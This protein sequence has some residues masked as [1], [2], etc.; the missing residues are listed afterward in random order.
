V[1]YL[2][3]AAS[4]GNK[5]IIGLNSD[6]SVRKLKGSTRP[7]QN[8]TSRSHIL[9]SLGFVDAVVPFEED[10][11][12]LLIEM[13]RPDVLVKGGDWPTEKIAG[14]E[15]VQSYGGRVISIPL[16]EGH[17]TTNIEKRIKS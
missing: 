14:S 13:V 8:I 1:E 2:A 16:I 5:L 4:L 11:P 12:I 10:T 17:S 7:I 9:A 15:F 6:A 3:K